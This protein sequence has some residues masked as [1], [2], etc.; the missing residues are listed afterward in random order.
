VH[1]TEGR[2]ENPLSST[3]TIV[4]PWRAAFFLTPAKSSWSS[5]RSRPRRAHVP[6][7]W[8]FAATTP[9]LK[10]DTPQALKEMRIMIDSHWRWDWWMLE[11][12]PNFEPL[13]NEP[14]FKIMMDEVRADMAAQ[15][16]R[17]R[18]MERN[19]ELEPIPEA[20]PATTH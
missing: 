8:A 20:A 11:K 13:W 10:G 19:G 16:A 7:S 5:V 6:A 9:A 14:E 12:D 3:K 15:L 2:S 1:W 17:V 4:A 18:E